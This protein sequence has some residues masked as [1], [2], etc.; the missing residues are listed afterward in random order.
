MLKRETVK[1]AYKFSLFKRNEG[2]A[3]WARAKVGRDLFLHH[4]MSSTCIP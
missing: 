3:S 2:G 4:L 1:A